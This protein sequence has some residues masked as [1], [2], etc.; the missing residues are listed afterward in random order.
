M[1]LTFAGRRKPPRDRPL[2]HARR[3]CCSPLPIFSDDASILAKRRRRRVSAWHCTHLHCGHGPLPP[4]RLLP[5]TTCNAQPRLSSRRWRTNHS[6]PCPLCRARRAAGTG[7]NTLRFWDDCAH[8]SCDAFG[9]A[10]RAPPPANKDA[11]A[12]TTVQPPATQNPTYAG[13]RCMDCYL[14]DTKDDCK[15]LPATAAWPVPHDFTP[16]AMGATDKRACYQ[17]AFSPSP[18][19]ARFL[20]RCHGACGNASSG[21]SDAGCGVVRRRNAGRWRDIY[22]TLNRRSAAA[23]LFPLHFPSF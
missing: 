2:P 12:R 9:A 8:T 3:L 18:A 21:S 17:A 23:R 5:G 7:V 16:S 13:K 20:P 1:L 14:G 4:A 6:L 22:R 19:P 11:A 15:R 10:P